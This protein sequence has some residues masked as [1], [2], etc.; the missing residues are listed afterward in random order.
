MRKIFILFL[1]F[2]FIFTGCETPHND[3]VQP[4]NSVPQEEILEQFSQLVD[5]RNQADQ[6]YALDNEEKWKKFDEECKQSILDQFSNGQPDFESF[7][8][9]QKNNS[10][11]LLPQKQIDA[12]HA[13]KTR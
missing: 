4:T 9:E 10:N 6:K 7:F 2:L 12:Y 8:K 5:Q 1:L 11:P 3:Q 13:N